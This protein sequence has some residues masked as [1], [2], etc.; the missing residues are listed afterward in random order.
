MLY[1]TKQ[2]LVFDL[3]VLASVLQPSIDLLPLP[4]LETMSLATMSSAIPLLLRLSRQSLQSSAVVLE[5]QLSC[6]SSLRCADLETTTRPSTSAWVSSL[7]RTSLS[8]L[9]STSTAVSGLLRHLWEVQAQPSRRSLMVLASLVS[10]LVPVCMFTS[11][12]ST[13]SSDCF[14]TQS[15]SRRT[16]WFTGRSG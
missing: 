11:Q 8:R 1:C 4:R 3:H 10:L 13:S 16:L 15:T 6:Q 2:D 12:P 14:D 7:L 5:L 9:S